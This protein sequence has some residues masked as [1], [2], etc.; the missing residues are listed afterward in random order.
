VVTE[1]PLVGRIPASLEIPERFQPLQHW[2][3]GG[4]PDSESRHTCHSH[5]FDVRRQNYLMT[6]GER[7]AA[8]ESRFSPEA[9]ELVQFGGCNDHD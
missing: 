8:M 3:Q 9:Q 7:S 4:R 6:N 5:P 1:I 2:G